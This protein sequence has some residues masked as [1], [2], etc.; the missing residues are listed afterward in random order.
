MPIHD[1][2]VWLMVTD[3]ATWPS[4]PVPPNGNSSP[5]AGAI[6]GRHRGTIDWRLRWATFGTTAAR[7]TA[8]CAKRGGLT[9]RKL[10]GARPAPHRPLGQLSGA[11]Y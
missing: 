5:R 1:T 6:S 2:L 11:P 8:V 7:R 3:D 9:Q 10:R 4:C